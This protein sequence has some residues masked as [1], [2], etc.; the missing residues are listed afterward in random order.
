MSDSIDTKEYKN[1]KYYDE[2]YDFVRENNLDIVKWLNNLDSYNAGYITEALG[3]MFSGFGLITKLNKFK[4]CKGNFSRQQIEIIETYKDLFYKDS[5]KINIRG[6]GGDISDITMISKTDPDHILIISSKCLSTEQVTSFD[7]GPMS[8]MA[9]KYEKIGKKISYGFLVKNKKKTDKVFSESTESTE[10][11]VDIYERDDSIVI[12][13]NDLNNAYNQFKMYFNNKTI[14][15]IISS[16]KKSL[17]LKMHQILSVSK[18]MKLKNNGIKKILWGHIQRSGK[19]YI[20]AGSIFKDSIGKDKCNYLIVTNAINETEQEYFNIFLQYIQFENFNVQRLESKNIEEVENL[21]KTNK[22][23]IIIV[24]ADYLKTTTGK[25]DNAEDKIKKIP[26]LKDMKPEFIFLDESHYG[27]TTDRA[28]MMM[29]YY[30]E[31][32]THVDITATYF[33]PVFN[34]NI[35]KSNCVL[36]DLEDIK[37]CKTI[38]NE[39]SQ[40][41]LMKKHGED[42]VKSILDAYTLDDI[43]EE[44]LKFP[45]L[46]VLTLELKPDIMKKI[47][48]KTKN[49]YKGWSTDAA[50]LITQAYNEKENKILL[51]NKFQ[52]EDAVLKL[53]YMIFGKKDEFGYDDEYP[54]EIVF[55]ERYKQICQKFNSRIIGEGN[56]RKEPMIIMAFLPEINIDKISDTTIKLLK[57]NNVIP[58]YEIISINSKKTKNPK[59][60]IE[61]ARKKARINNK[62]G[63]LV[64]SGRQCHL[65]VTIRDCDIVLLLTNCKSYDMI[66]QMMFRAMTEGEGKKCG[67]VFSIGCWVCLGLVSAAFASC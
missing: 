1:I 61:E 15:D 24:S 59:D 31:N 43:Q 62:K 12:D 55:M 48:D 56:F 33:K 19:S 67:F 6:R 16:S 13:W 50:Q 38:H 60:A 21:V 52:N 58:D 25:D 46:C 54:S 37:L 3:V 17:C 49:S 28:N 63:V 14:D 2:L 29:D 10:Y 7:I 41:R 20:M 30:G 42:V 18:T 32:S 34:H 51:N 40:N 57:E 5:K 4:L 53:W 47:I 66:Y 11:L 8:L 44:Y 22:K 9:Q 36:W 64:L 35:P 65:G 23:N 45:E 39:E 27:G 26:W